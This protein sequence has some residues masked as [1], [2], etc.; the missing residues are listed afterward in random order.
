[1]SICSLCM[2]GRNLSSREE[3]E[4]S[5]APRSFWRALFAACVCDGVNREL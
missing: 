3:K 5:S 1:M 4:S 2:G